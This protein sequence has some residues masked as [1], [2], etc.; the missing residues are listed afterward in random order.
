MTVIVLQCCCYDT[1]VISRVAVVNTV[2]NV[3]LSIDVTQQMMLRLIDDM[4][5]GKVIRECWSQTEIMS[6]Q[7]GLCRCFVHEGG[8]LENRQ[9]VAQIHQIASQISIFFCG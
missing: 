5:Y 1:I 9:S 6:V 4:I 7:S 3:C 2:R 8:K